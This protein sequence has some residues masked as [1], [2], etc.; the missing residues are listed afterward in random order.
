MTS[1]GSPAIRPLVIRSCTISKGSG[2]VANRLGGLSSTACLRNIE[3]NPSVHESVRFPYA[4]QH[5]SIQVDGNDH[6]STQS[7]TDRNRHRIYQPSVKQPAIVQSDRRK[8]SRQGDGCPNGIQHRT[9]A[10][11]RSRPVPISAATAAY[12]NGNS[13]IRAF[14]S[15]TQSR[16]ER[17]AAFSCLRPLC[18]KI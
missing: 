1:G 18:R 8:Q 9:S 7:P 5:I 10:R 4:A 2:A 15:A 14:S 12:C 11:Q 3:A 17:H 13:S 16:Q 6:I